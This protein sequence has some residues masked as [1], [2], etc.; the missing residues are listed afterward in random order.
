MCWVVEVCP[1]IGDRNGMRRHGSSVGHVLLMKRV[2]EESQQ[3]HQKATS[4]KGEGPIGCQVG[5]NGL[6][7]SLGAVPD[8][9]HEEGE[10]EV[11]I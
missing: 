11:L 9:Y 3:I 1:E 7:M 5:S 6:G 10:E 4:G 2:P 8:G